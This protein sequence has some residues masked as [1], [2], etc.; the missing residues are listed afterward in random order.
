MKELLIFLIFIPVISFSQNR[1]T[2]EFNEADSVFNA[3]YPK[4]KLNKIIKSNLYQI[5]DSNF[6]KHNPKTEM[7]YSAICKSISKDC[8][9]DAG[10]YAVC[11]GASYIFSDISNNDVAKYSFAGVSVILLGSSINEL[12]KH[13]KFKRWS[14]FAKSGKDR[15]GRQFKLH[16]KKG[17]IKR[18]K[19][20]KKM[21]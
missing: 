12:V 2:E 14:R 6:Y 7:D 19:E 9:I 17:K 5:L 11:A 1:I 15:K 18:V 20:L 10:A 21:R 13:L 8:L 4:E 16:I 3:I